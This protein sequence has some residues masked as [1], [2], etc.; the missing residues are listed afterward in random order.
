MNRLNLIKELSRLNF[1][2]LLQIM[3]FMKYLHSRIIRF[4]VTG[5]R[6][7][8]SLKVDVLHV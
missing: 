8:K 4:S 5:Y 3:A 2:Y 6:E 1:M 7:V